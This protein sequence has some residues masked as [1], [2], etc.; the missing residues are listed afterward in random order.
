MWISGGPPQVLPESTSIRLWNGQIE[1][2]RL[3]FPCSWRRKATAGDVIPILRS[4]TFTA[5]HGLM[6]CAI[7]LADSRE[8]HQLFVTLHGREKLLLVV[9]SLWFL[10]HIKILFCVPIFSLLSNICPSAVCSSCYLLLPSL[11]P[12]FATGYTFFMAGQDT[13]SQQL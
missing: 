10:P 12:V 11:Y 1:S 7:S 3:N 5:G 6:P 4:L 2:E 13:S 8:G 9:Q